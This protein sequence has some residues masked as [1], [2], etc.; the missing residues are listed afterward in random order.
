MEM[1]GPETRKGSQSGRGGPVIN[2]GPVQWSWGE[3]GYA[4]DAKGLPQ[5]GA[6]WD[7]P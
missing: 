3:G 6:F 5:V 7:G 2:A 4:A 1:D